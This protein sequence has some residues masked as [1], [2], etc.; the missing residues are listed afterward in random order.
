[1]VS[2]SCRA[3]QIGERLESSRPDPRPV[4]PRMIPLIFGSVFSL[5]ISVVISSGVAESGKEANA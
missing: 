5:W 2:V 1:M 3:V 4:V